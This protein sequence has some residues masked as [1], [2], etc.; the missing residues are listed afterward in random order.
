MHRPTFIM[1]G[2]RMMAAISSGFSLEAALDRL[3]IVEGRDRHVG[4]AGLG[5]ALAAGDRL[6][7]LDVAEIVAGGCGFTLTSAASCRPW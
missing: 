7:I 6:R 2:S 3:Q 5:H 1:I 4:D